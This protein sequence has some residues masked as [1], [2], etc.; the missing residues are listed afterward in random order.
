MLGRSDDDARRVRPIE[1]A[2]VDRHVTLGHELAAAWIDADHEHFSTEFTFV[3]VAESIPEPVRRRV[4]ELD[5]RT[6]L[7]YGF[8]GHYDVHVV[9]VVPG[10][11]TLVAS[12]GAD[13]AEALATWD[14][15]E[16]ETPSLL[17]LV[18]RRLQL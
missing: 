2:S 5:E 10:A 11:E 9:V 6:L 1:P 3:L 13:V 14:P 18:S 4:S 16:R 15:L 7:S 17:D 12:D 8:T